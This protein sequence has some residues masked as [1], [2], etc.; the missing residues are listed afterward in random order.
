MVRVMV[1]VRVR[2]RTAQARSYIWNVVTLRLYL[3]VGLGLG[4]GLGRA[5]LVRGYVQLV[6]AVRKCSSEI[7][8]SHVRAP[9]QLAAVVPW[10]GGR[11]GEG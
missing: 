8:A 2:V 10:G 4:L 7:G 1:V 5:H 6:A 3:E 11:G 9:R